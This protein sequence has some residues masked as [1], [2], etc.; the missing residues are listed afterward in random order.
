MKPDLTAIAGM[1]PY[2]DGDFVAVRDGYFS[3]GGFE[4]YAM[5][6][7][8]VYT[9]CTVIVYYGSGY[10]EVFQCSIIYHSKREP[11]EMVSI[12][13]AAYRR[14]QRMVGIR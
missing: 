14:L 1:Y 4:P 2:I 9:G 12:N 5:Q 8:W 7:T 3:D 6:D 10:P 11:I 13:P